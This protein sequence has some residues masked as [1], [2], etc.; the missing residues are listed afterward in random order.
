MIRPLYL[1]RRMPHALNLTTYLC[2]SVCFP[3]R[4]PIVHLFWRDPPFLSLLSLS[5]VVATPYEAF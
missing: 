1:P 2:A 5:Q 3:A 4:A